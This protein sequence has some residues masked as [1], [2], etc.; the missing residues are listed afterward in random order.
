MSNADAKKF[1]APVCLNILI[2][3]INVVYYNYSLLTINCEKIPE[4]QSGDLNFPFRIET[5]LTISLAVT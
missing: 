1:I 5:Y 3:K 4:P 2:A